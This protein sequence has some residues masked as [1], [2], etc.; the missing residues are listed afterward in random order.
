MGFNA[1]KKSSCDVGMHFGNFR[2]YPVKIGNYYKD[3]DAFRKMPGAFR[4]WSS[5]FRHIGLLSASIYC[6]LVSSVHVNM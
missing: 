6:V 5:P 3:S 2:D 4:Q 1:F